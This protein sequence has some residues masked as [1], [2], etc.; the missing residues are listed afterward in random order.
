MIQ[1]GAFLGEQTRNLTAIVNTDDT[2]LPE[3]N[4]T[5]KFLK[6]HRASNKQS[7]NLALENQIEAQFDGRMKL[8]RN[9]DAAVMLLIDPFNH[10]IRDPAATKLLNTLREQFV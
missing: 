9:L 8:A 3:T 1:I 5:G 6:S 7:I 2:T 4:I 10:M